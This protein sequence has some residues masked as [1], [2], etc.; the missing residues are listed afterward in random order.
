M[1]A[2]ARTCGVRDAAG[3]R[4]VKTDPAMTMAITAAATIAIRRAVGRYHHGSK[5]PATTAMSVVS[6]AAGGGE[7]RRAA[8]GIEPASPSEVAAT[9]AGAGLPGSPAMGGL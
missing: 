7:W 3:E 5:E 8:A 1:G 2:S 4:C 6:I 9:A